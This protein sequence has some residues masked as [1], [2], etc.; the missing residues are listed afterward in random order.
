V[1]GRLDA[2]IQARGRGAVAGSREDQVHLTLSGAGLT[3]GFKHYLTHGAE[4]DQCVADVLLGP[5]GKELLARDGE[6]R[7]IRVVVPGP[8]ALA[9]AHPYFSIG[10]MRGGGNV[11]NLVGDFLNAWSFRLAH[12]EFQ[13]RTLEA[14][15]GMV[16]NT[17]VPAAWI[18]GSDT[19]A[20]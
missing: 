8:L 9:A 19:L 12:P 2:T 1:A 5:G 11:P 16:F 13:S 18:I 17:T 4:F 6:P 14:D 20:E 3:N 7:L 15:C 10:L